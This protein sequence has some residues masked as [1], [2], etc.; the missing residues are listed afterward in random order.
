MKPIVEV[1]NLWDRIYRIAS[2]DFPELKMKP[3]GQ[4]GAQSKWLIFKADLPA[5]VTID[6]KITKATM[7][8]SFWKGAKTAPSQLISLS[9]LPHGA[10]FEV[11]GQTTVIRV[12]L[13]RTCLDWTEMA[14]AEIRAG[15]TTARQLLR[16]YSDK[17]TREVG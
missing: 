16:F 10:T 6:W 9:S 15:L 11:V 17:L 13:S 2:A 12:P 7:D 14:D 3:P 4:K 5:R 8:L 1:G